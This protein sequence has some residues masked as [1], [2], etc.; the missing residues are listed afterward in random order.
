MK[1]AFRAVGSVLIVA[2]I[3]FLVK[4]TVRPA[5]SQGAAIATASGSGDVTCH[6]RVRDKLISRL[7]GLRPQGQPLWNMACKERL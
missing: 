3:L 2:S 6:L 4:W 7:Q 1:T 5:A